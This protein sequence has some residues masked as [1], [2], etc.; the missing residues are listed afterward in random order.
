MELAGWQILVLFGAGLSAGFVDAVAG[1]GGLITVPTLLGIGLSPHLALGTNKLQS[2]CGTCLAVW[3]YARAG[4]L[5]WSDVRLTVGL[6]FLASVGGT[7][8]VTH[9]DSSLLR[10]L[11]PWLLLAVGLYTLGSPRLGAEARRP[12]MHP[13]A[14]ALLFSSLLGF[15]D[16]FFGPGTGSFWALSF[17]L[18]LGLDLR[19]ATAHTKAA[20]LASNLG[21]LAVFL[22]GG[23]VRLSIALVMICGQLIGAWLG[24][25][26]VIARGAKF[27]RL[28]FLAVVFALTFKLLWQQLF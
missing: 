24:A 28:V 23:Q 12:R 10:G 6:T 15:Y 19:R 5:R 22:P 17:V 11:I 13:V 20:N 16:G 4:L 18:L 9:V 1:G 21:S 8:A 3:R 2:A 14:F 7:L 26:L 27:I 25:H